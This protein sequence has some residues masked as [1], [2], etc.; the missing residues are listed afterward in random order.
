MSVL[1][2]ESKVC[3]MSITVQ[4]FFTVNDFASNVSSYSKE[5]EY[6]SL[7]FSI[8]IKQ[9]ATLPITPSFQFVN[10]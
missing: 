9:L 8:H 10:Y 7:L 6:F 2:S 1:T 5:I 4:P 3:F